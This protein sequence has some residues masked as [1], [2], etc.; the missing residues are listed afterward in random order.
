MNFLEILLSKKSSFAQETE[1]P[2]GPY[3]LSLLKQCARAMPAYGMPGQCPVG[4]RYRN[5]IERFSVLAQK[6]GAAAFHNYLNTLGPNAP[7]PSAAIDPL[8]RR[9]RPARVRASSLLGTVLLV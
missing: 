5:F 1:G 4:L 9:T 2:M 7:P 3:A 6:S 8:T